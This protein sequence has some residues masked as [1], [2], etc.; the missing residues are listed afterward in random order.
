[1]TRA[2]AVREPPRRVHDSS[3]S[4]RQQAAVV[5]I[6]ALTLLAGFWLNRLPTVGADTAQ[7]MTGSDWIVRC[8]L[9]GPRTKCG[10]VARQD[11]SMVGPFSL[12]QY[13]PD[14]AMKGLKLSPADRMTGQSVVSM[15][16]FF[17]MLAVAWATISRLGPSAGWP[18]FL[19]VLLTGP[20]LYYGNA[21]WGEMLAASILVCFTA[22][23]L[24]RLPPA[25]IALAAF[26]AALTRET[27]FPLL[28]ALGVLGLWVARERTKEPVRMHLAAMAIGM[29]L[30]TGASALFN[31][32]R[33][34]SPFNEFYLQPKFRVHDL[35]TTAEFFAGLFVAPNGGLLLFWASAC[36]L[37]A[38]T[39]VSAVRSRG[40]TRL[41]GIGVLAVLLLVSAS[42]ARWW[43]PYGWHAW[44]PRLTIVWI[45][46]LV[47]LSIVACGRSFGAIVYR[48]IRS[49]VGLLAV[50][51]LLLLS[52][53]PQVGFL[54]NSTAV[55]NDFFRTDEYCTAA[56]TVESIEQPDVLRDYYRC[57]HFR[58]WEKP[59]I[60]L[61]AMR[62]FE[63]FAPL[64][65]AACWAAAI[66]AL[67]YLM[68][69]QLATD[70]AAAPVLDAQRAEGV[71]TV[72]PTA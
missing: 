62:S 28:F 45:P 56:L 41:V 18:A 55:H 59:S 35:R 72:R 33:Y 9:H 47:L 58:A 67:L 52:A 17:A 5:V 66:G 8:L 29:G 19:L 68:R 39:V 22:S 60:L 21:T 53:L 1:V 15:A 13:A 31:V 2:E 14:V 10:F 69:L 4:R 25:L 30:A 23:V 3:R 61:S 57:V 11:E 37:L 12:V 40:T 16:A 70:E 71:P 6:V 50:T 42:L 32:F 51:L 27:A 63:S 26:T 38:L 43:M 36:L 34:G 24:L 48:S 46:S 7:V 44:G 64:V 54:V 65:L 49:N 20:F